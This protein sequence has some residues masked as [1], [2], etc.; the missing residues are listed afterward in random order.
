LRKR[1]R[2]P[3]IGK[4]IHS[5]DD[6]GDRFEAQRSE[7]DAFGSFDLTV[8][9]R[10]QLDV[11]VMRYCGMLSWRRIAEFEHVSKWAVRDRHQRALQAL[12]SQNQHTSRISRGHNPV[13]WRAAS[14]APSGDMPDHA[15]QSGAAHVAAEGGGCGIIRLS[16]EALYQ[17]EEEEA[18]AAE[19]AS[20]DESC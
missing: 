17:Q 12:Q 14:A 10:K 8:L 9:T 3:D 16:L 19:A 13:S 7:R 18:A 15:S 20:R 5:S 6:D 1:T 4:R 2:G 11:L